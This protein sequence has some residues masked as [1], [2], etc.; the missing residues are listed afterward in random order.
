MS[1]HTGV[2]AHYELRTAVPRD[3]I[4]KAIAEMMLARMAAERISRRVIRLFSPESIFLPAKLFPQ[5]HFTENEPL[6]LPRAELP[7]LRFIPTD[8]THAAKIRH[9]DAL[10]TISQYLWS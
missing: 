8:R 2:L 4:P 10:N 7:G 5:T 3:F 1:S 9:Q 6:D